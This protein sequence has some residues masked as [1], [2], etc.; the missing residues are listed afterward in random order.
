[1]PD[2]A[3]PSAARISDC[4]CV[5][6]ARSLNQSDQDFLAFARFPR[7]PARLEAALTEATASVSSLP[8]HDPTPPPFLACC[9]IVSLESRLHPVT[10]THFVLLCPDSFLVY[11]ARTRSR[12]QE[13]TKKSLIKHNVVAHAGS[14]IADEPAMT[15]IKRFVAHP[16]VPLSP[17]S[18]H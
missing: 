6:L 7:M 12:K 18:R 15:I 17:R 8:L 9:V 16:S 4:G 3:V 13:N 14:S 2:C 5:W 10:L 1:M 11:M